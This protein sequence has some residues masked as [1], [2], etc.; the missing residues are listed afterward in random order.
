ME[1]PGFVWKFITY[2]KLKQLLV[3]I[4]ISIASLIISRYQDL[5]IHGDPFDNF[6]TGAGSNVILD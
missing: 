2:N 4:I 5:L 1:V 6:E 3:R